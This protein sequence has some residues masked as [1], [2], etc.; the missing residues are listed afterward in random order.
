MPWRSTANFIS[1]LNFQVFNYKISIFYS[2]TAQ[3]YT[4]EVQPLKLTRLTDD[5]LVTKVTGKHLVQKSNSMVKFFRSENIDFAC[6]PKNLEKLFVNLDRIQI[7]HTKIATLTRSDLQPFGSRLRK[8]W[9]QNSLIEVIPADLFE[10]TKNLETISLV[11][12]YIKYVG[13]G[14]FNNLRKLTI[15]FFQNNPCH[16]AG[17]AYDRTG[18]DTLIA[19]IGSKCTDEEVFKRV[20]LLYPQRFTSISIHIQI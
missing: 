16:P 12:N 2:F 19:E 4:C 3:N 15:M 9:F 5:C 20:R 11:N 6:F 1:K 7:N 8:L 17:H 10:D 14:T 13:S 18:V